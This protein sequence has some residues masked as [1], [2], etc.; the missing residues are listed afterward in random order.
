MFAHGKLC[1]IELLPVSLSVAHVALARGREFDA[2]CTHMEMLC[3][4]F[5]TRIMRDDDRLVY[6]A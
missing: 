4:G 3:A 2:I 1:R 5:G 6:E